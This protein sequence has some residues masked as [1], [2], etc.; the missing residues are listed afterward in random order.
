LALLAHG[1]YAEGWREYEW[2]LRI[3]ELGKHSRAFE[4][5]ALERRAAVRAEAAVTAEQGL[6]DALQFSSFADDRFRSNGEFG[7]LSRPRNRLPACWR[8]CPGSLRVVTVDGPL[9]PH[10]AHV[11][12][13]SLPGLLG[14]GVADI[15]ADRPYLAADSARRNE[16]IAAL[17]PYAAD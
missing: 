15:P 9:P 16:A 6:G 1:E 11:P 7:S 3:P 4:R 14:I 17:A 12:L 2:R 10:D 8:A 5:S 13:L